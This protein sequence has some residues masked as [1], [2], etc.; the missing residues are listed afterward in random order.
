MSPDVS[1]NNGRVSVRII[2]AD[3]NKLRDKLLMMGTMAESAI[4]HA[5]QALF[6][7]NTEICEQVIADDD[8]IDKLENE[9]DKLATD[10]MVLRQPAAGDLRFTVTSLHTAPILERVADHAV[11]I[12][13]HVRALNS[14]PQLK[15][16]IDLPTMSAITQEMLRDSMNA[17]TQGDIELARRTIKKDDQVDDFYHKIYD[18]VLD[19]MQREPNTVKRGSELLFVIKHLERIADYATNIC[20]MVI[21]MIEG[22]IIKHTEEAS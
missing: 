6:E 4:D 3:L 1:V 8:E 21:Y 5:M 15:P 16:Y 20:E 11:N 22:R 14:E 12:A 17:L 10:I 7:R 9:I 13:K 19:L 2:E 18:E